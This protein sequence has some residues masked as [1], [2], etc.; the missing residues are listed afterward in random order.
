[1]NQHSDHDGI[2]PYIIEGT[3]ITDDSN[4]TVK[5][6]YNPPI[7]RREQSLVHTIDFPISKWSLDN[8]ELSLS[9][10]ITISSETLHFSTTGYWLILLVNENIS[11]DTNNLLL[12]TYWTAFVMVTV[13]L[14]TLWVEEYKKHSIDEW[15]K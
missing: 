8:V 9:N 7:Y 3:I 14:Q 4:A 1:M 6:W 15:Y 13:L 5:E 11:S 10:T 12:L 2:H